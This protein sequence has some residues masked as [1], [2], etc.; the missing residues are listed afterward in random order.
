MQ[1]ANPASS[2]PA[3]RPSSTPSFTPQHQPHRPHHRSSVIGIGNREE[4]GKRKKS[5]PCHNSQKSELTVTLTAHIPELSYLNNHILIREIFLLQVMHSASLWLAAVSLLGAFSAV[6]GFVLSSSPRPSSSTTAL[7]DI[8]EWRDQWYTYPGTGDDR[9]L[10][11]ESSGTPREICLLPFPFDEVL[12]Q[13][14]QK[15]LRLYEERFLK[16]F[17]HATEKNCGVVGMGLCAEAGIIQ[18]VPLCEI[19]AFNKMDGFGI[20]MTIRVVSRAK[21]LEV[22]SSPQVI[23]G[24]LDA[25]LMLLFG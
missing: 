23:F 24:F 21:I 6:G 13:G 2:Q 18:S 8:S 4:K 11:K 16:L 14:E 15:Q 3:S 22:V 1:E 25:S 12:L 17:E 20:F 19:E 7:K 9:T 10:G 5:S